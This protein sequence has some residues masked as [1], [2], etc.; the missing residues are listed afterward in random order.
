MSVSDAIKADSKARSRFVIGV[1]IGLII[2][3]IFGEAYARLYPPA[4]IREYLGDD[5]PLRGIY[6]PDPVLGVGYRSIDDYR[7]LEAPPFAEIHPLNVPRT[8]L[9]FGNSFA[10]QMSVTARNAMPSYRVLFFREAK[11]RLHLRIAEARLLLENGLRPER[12]IFTLIPREIA[13]YVQFPLSSVYINRNGALTYRPRLPPAPWDVVLSRSRLALT[14]W[15]GAGFHSHNPDFRFPLIFATVPPVV[16][17]DFRRLF[18]TLGELSRRYDVP[19]TVVIFS[20]RRQI[21]ESAA[22]FAPQNAVLDLGTETGLDVF[23]PRDLLLAYPDRRALYLP[24]GHYTP[25]GDELIL[26]A[27]RAHLEK[28]GK[29]EKQSAR[30]VP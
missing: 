14:A 6:R 5:S 23:D 4:A 11:D 12:M 2:P 28:L 15:V 8:W 17:D 18:S 19:V 22:K 13:A 30:T 21:L 24:D 16:V 25:L 9:F 3:L 1:M 10:R 7:P 27:L 29:P 26:A 20:D